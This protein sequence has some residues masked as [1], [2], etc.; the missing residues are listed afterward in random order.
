MKNIMSNCSS[1]KLYPK[2][3]I[4]VQPFAVDNN[5]HLIPCCQCDAMRNFDDPKYIE[6]LKH[7]KISDYDSIMEILTSDV[8]LLFEEGLM[9]NEGFKMCYIYCLTK[10]KTFKKQI[11]YNNNKKVAEVDDN[12]KHRQAK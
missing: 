4:G 2:C 9:N 10:E 7:V 6:F 1:I 5:G 11:F 3:L 8:W 12:S